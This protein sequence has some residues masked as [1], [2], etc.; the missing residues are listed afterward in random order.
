MNDP[1][2]DKIKNEL[3]RK[4]RCHTVILYGSHARGGATDRSDYDVMGVRLGGKKLR[5]AEKRDGKF[6][7]AFVFPEKELQKVGE[8]RL[9]MKG[10][11][12]VYQKGT[13][14]TRFIKEL[15]RAL[16]RRYKPWPPDQIKMLRVWAHKMLERIELGD[17][18]GNFRRSWLQW[19]L[20]EDYFHIRKKRY[21]G[22]KESF[23]WLKKSDA[24][25]YKLFESVLKKPND[26]RILRKLVIRVAGKI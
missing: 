15:D 7:D 11:K 6:I 21:W 18:E 24:A 25:T 13:F 3:I 16:K 23:A 19:E 2:L 5:W 20:L 22:S 9:Y 14:G 10:C 8:D 17:V 12:I 1:F 26:L 4:Y